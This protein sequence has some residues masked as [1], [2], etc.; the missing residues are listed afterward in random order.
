MIGSA[1]SRK[2]KYAKTYLGKSTS[3]SATEVANARQAEASQLAQAVP[4]EPEP[5]ADATEVPSG[6]KKPSRQCGG[7][8]GFYLHRIHKCTS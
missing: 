2:Q 6:I 5:L 8:G 4:Q 7:R 1:P 3:A